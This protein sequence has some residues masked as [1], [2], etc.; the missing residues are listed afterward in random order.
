MERQT[1]TRL[2][3]SAAN[4]LADRETIA[5]CQPAQL[6]YASRTHSK[7][8]STSQVDWEKNSRDGRPHKGCP[9]ISS[10]RTM[11]MTGSEKDKRRWAQ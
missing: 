5:R 4:T 3:H 7:K 2:S 10:G 8:G 11:G 9:G 1:P 6:V